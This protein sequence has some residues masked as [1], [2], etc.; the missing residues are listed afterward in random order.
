MLGCLQTLDILF[1][2]L[3]GP[4][5]DPFVGF[6]T[7]LPSTANAAVELDEFIHRT[8]RPNIPL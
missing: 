8:D 2:Q 3:D 6:Q 7:A 4:R 1:A 5:K